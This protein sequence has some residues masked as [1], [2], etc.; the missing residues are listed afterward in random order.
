ML[1]DLGVPTLCPCGTSG[2]YLDIDKFF[3][4]HDRSK[5]KYYYGNSLVGLMLCN[6]IR[7]CELGASAFSSPYGNAPYKTPE[8][9]SGN[10]LRLAIPR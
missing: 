3:D 7:G 2:V 4:D 10:F 9:V 5:R 8:E 1:R 6:G